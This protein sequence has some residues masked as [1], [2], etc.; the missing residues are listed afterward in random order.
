MKCNP[1]TLRLLYDSSTSRS[2]SACH[3]KHALSLSNM[4]LLI[5]AKSEVSKT[6][7]LIGNC[8]VAAFGAVVAFG[9]EKKRKKSEKLLELLECHTPS[10]L[11]GG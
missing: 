6:A 8:K 7:V 5:P 9:L 4:H 10:Q 2:I 3:A 11:T 1:G